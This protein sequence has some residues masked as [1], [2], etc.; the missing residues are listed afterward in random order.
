MSNLVDSIIPFLFL[1]RNVHKLLKL[2]WESI[3][4]SKD[5]LVSF[6]YTIHKDETSDDIY[7]HVGVIQG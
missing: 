1:V 5:K 6:S 4:F 7:C 2:Q 3:K